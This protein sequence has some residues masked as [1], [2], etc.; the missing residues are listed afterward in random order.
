[1]HIAR[2]RK[3]KRTSLGLALLAAVLLAPSLATAQSAS[4]TLDRV[5]ASGK[6]TFG[7]F[8]AARPLSYRNAAGNADGYSV[9]LCRGIGAVVKQQ[10]GLSSLSVQF[11]PIDSDPV[12]AVKSGR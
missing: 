1:M 4:G 2:T 3:D 8:G 11:V 10:L 7:Y 5:R 12:A 6:I 9:A